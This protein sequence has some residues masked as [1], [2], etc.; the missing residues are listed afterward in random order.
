M[1]PGVLAILVLTGAA[2]AGC[3]RPSDLSAQTTADARP[4]PQAAWPPHGPGCEQLVLCCEQA[5][6][7]D[8]DAARFCQRSVASNP[9]DCPRVLSAV[10]TYVIER[11]HTVPPLCR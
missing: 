4:S 11:G 5:T 7:Q 2:I 6:P 10:R 9:G 8:N 1:R 3:R